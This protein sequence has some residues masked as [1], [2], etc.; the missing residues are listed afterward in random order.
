MKIKEMLIVVANIST[1]LST[2]PTKFII[3]TGTYCKCAVPLKNDTF[4]LYRSDPQIRTSELRIRIV[5]FVIKW[6]KRLQ[7]NPAFYFI[8][9]S[10][11]YLR[12]N[13]NNSL[14]IKP[15]NTEKIFF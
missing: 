5:L 9:C 2:F 3:T 14:C 11:L 1:A 12:K 10:L 8:F 7:K 13:Y 4:F 15:K 6:L